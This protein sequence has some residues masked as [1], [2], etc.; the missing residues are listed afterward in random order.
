MSQPNPQDFLNQFNQFS[1]DTQKMFE[2]WTK[3]NQAFLKNAEMMTEFSLNTI[4]SY[5]EMGLENMRQ[6]AGIDSPE[7]AKD[8]SDKQAEMLN[9]ISQQMLADAQRMSELGSSMHDEVIK[10]MGD[11]QGQ[12]TEQMQANMQKTADQAT[13]A[14]QEYAANMS[15]MAEQASGTVKAATKTNTSNTTTETNTTGTTNTKTGTAGASSTG[16][17]TNR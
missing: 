13:K 11:V 2:P 7:T 12:T 17:S 16:K 9:V 10:V 3:L 15:K 4:K 5:S 14:G 6:V 1:G 8:F